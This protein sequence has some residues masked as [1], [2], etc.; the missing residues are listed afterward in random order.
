VR[1]RC[2]ALTTRDAAQDEYLADKAAGKVNFEQDL[3][4]R[5]RARGRQLLARL[6]T[7]LGR[8]APARRC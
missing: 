2:R 6:P 5:A 3:K 8:P 7:C 4:A 1:V